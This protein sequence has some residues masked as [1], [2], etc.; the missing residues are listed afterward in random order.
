[1]QYRTG[2]ILTVPVNPRITQ[3]AEQAR[4]AGIRGVCGKADIKCVVEGIEA[5]LLKKPYFHN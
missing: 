2:E 5:L 1:M 3:L 4:K